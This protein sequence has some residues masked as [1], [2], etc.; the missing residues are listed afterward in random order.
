MAGS[1]RQRVD[2]GDP[3]LIGRQYMTPAPARP[4]QIPSLRARLGDDRVP[5]LAEDVPGHV[6][7]R[8]ERR[9]G[10]EGR[11]RALR[12]PLPIVRRMPFQDVPIPPL[13]SWKAPDAADQGAEGRD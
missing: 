2:L 13:S 1:S 10:V 11:L 12:V 6:L 7:N 9:P 4:G 8:F 3:S 5:V